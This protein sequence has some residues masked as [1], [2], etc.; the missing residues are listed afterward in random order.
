M[1]GSRAMAEPGRDQASWLLSAPDLW[2]LPVASNIQCSGRFSSP[3]R[4][5]E[6]QGSADTATSG[7]LWLSLEFACVAAG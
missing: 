1:Q 5:W 6:P 3:A 2:V 4:L 7:S